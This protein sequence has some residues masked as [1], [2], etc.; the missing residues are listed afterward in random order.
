MSSHQVQMDLIVVEDLRALEV[1]EAAA[2]VVERYTVQRL[3]AALHSQKTCGCRSC[4]AK[5]HAWVD[6]AAGDDDELYEDLYVPARWEH[7][8]S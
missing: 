2:N 3:N 4:V 5:A 1:I 8:T 6:W 7:T